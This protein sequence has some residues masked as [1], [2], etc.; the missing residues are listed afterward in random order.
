MVKF[1]VQDDCANNAGYA[2]KPGITFVYMCTDTINIFSVPSEGFSGTFA[3]ELGPA[4]S[5][6]I[7]D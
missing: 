6:L 7:R 5:K 2:N 4:G 3:I 1:C